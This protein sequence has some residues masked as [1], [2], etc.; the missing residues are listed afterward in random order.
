[1]R[2]DGDRRD[3]AI[4]AFRSCQNAR[5]TSALMLYSEIIALLSDQH[6]TRKCALWAEREICVN[7]CGTYSNHWALTGLNCVARHGFCTKYVT[8]S[9]ARVAQRM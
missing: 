7:P 9:R 4:V 2:T 6:K 8:S 1:M 5:K 3:E